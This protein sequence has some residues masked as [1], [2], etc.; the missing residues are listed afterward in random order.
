MAVVLRSGR[1][2]RGDTAAGRLRRHAPGRGAVR[3]LPQP[4]RS[5]LRGRGL[6]HTDRSAL[7]HQLDLTDVGARDL[8]A[9]TVGAHDAERRLGVVFSGFE[10]TLFPVEQE[11]ED[12]LV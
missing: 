12:E 11:P 5:R 3:Q 2:R 1:L 10:A 7:L 8:A 4:S 6:S 9:E